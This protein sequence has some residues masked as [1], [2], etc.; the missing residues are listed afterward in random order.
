MHALNVI[1]QITMNETEL[2]VVASQL[3]APIVQKYFR[4]LAYQN[5]AAIVQGSPKEGETAES[6]LLRESAVKG[7]LEVLNDLLSIQAAQP[8]Q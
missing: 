5:A 4:M 3:A 8:E 1:P 6:Y 2:E 7:R